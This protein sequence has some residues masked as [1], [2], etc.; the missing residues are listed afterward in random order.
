MAQWNKHN[1]SITQ[2]ISFHFISFKTCKIQSGIWPF[3]M[4]N[5]DRTQNNGITRIIQRERGREKLKEEMW[6]KNDLHLKYWQINGITKWHINFRQ[7]WSW[8]LRLWES[9]IL[10]IAIPWWRDVHWTNKQIQKCLIWDWLNAQCFFTKR[11]IESTPSWYSP[12]YSFPRG[13]LFCSF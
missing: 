1:H 5:E 12:L 7:H 2:I 6:W 11:E 10:N 4:W 9:S 3:G 13:I 8:E